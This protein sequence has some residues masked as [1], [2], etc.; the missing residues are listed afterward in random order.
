ME[1]LLNE[2]KKEYIWNDYFGNIKKKY[3]MRVSKKNP[4]VIELDGKDVTASTTFSLIDNSKDSFLNIMEQTSKYFSSKY[5]CLAIF[6]VDEVSF[7]FENAET[8]INKINKNRNFMTDE[9]ISVFSQYF[10]EYFNKLNTKQNIFWHGKAFSIPKQKVNSYILYKSQSILNVFT[11]YFLKKNM[12]KDAGHI[13]LDEKI[14]RCKQIDYYKEVEKYSR[15]IL[16]LNGGKVDLD[17]YLKGNIKIIEETKRT[18]DT[19][20]DP[21]AFNEL[22]E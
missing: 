9:I 20:V 21:T 8:I 19:Y 18:T 16:Y 13:K 14:E 22:F 17:E 6:G 1:R 4:L 15:G 12:V 3:G 2:R 5:N 7:I 10:F 11:T